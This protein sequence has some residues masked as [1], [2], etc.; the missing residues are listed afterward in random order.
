[1]SNPIQQAIDGLERI[2][3]WD[4]L[5]SE[6]KMNYGSNGERDHFRG[7]ASDA[8]SALQSLQ[9][10]ELPEPKAYLHEQLGNCMTHAF[11]WTL[12][13]ERHP[14][15]ELNEFVPLYTADQLRTAVDAAMARG[16]EPQ[17]D[18]HRVPDA[19]WEALQRMIEDAQT[20]GPASKDD[21]MVVARWRARFVA[22]REATQP[23]QAEAPSEREAF[24]KRVLAV[25][26]AATSFA[27]KKA[28]DGHE[29]VLLELRAALSTQQAE[30]MSD[31]QIAAAFNDWARGHEGSAHVESFRAGARFAERRGT[32]KQPEALAQQERDREDAPC[33]DG[34]LPDGEIC[35]RCGGK[36][37]PSGIDGGSWVHI[38]AA[39]SSEGGSNG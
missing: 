21:A 32:T 7:V 39:R 34:L 29:A 37:G 2:V 9:G 15:K 8:L 23:T 16:A 28:R 33:P 27:T 13:Q 12:R 5:S 14:A 36:R 18:P 6:F 26:A 10:V 35:P 38:R 24:L 19:V 25:L 4:E 20:R 1:M 30:A 22:A 17:G 31:P 11:Y 3:R